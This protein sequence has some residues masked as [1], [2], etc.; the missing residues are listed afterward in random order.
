MAV[1]GYPSSAVDL[2]DR[3]PSIVACRQRSRLVGT[4]PRDNPSCAGIGIVCEPHRCGLW[5]TIWSQYRKN[6]YMSLFEKL[7]ELSVEILEIEFLRHRVEI[8]FEQVWDVRGLAISGK[9][10]E[11]LPVLE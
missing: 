1:E 11:S 9:A 6:C 10:A 4:C 2:A 3:N 5:G 8:R 7:N